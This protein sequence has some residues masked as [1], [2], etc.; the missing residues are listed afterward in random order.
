MFTFLWNLR[1]VAMDIKILIIDGVWME[2]PPKIIK[3]GLGQIVFNLWWHQL[4]VGKICKLFRSV[5]YSLY[6]MRLWTCAWHV[7][8]R[9]IIFSGSHSQF[10]TNWLQQLPEAHTKCIVYS[11]TFAILSNFILENIAKIHIF[12]DIKHLC[13]KYCLAYQYYAKEQLKVFVEVNTCTSP[14]QCWHICTWLL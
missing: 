7:Q 5:F 12:R 14:T 8:M 6:G 3:Q 13:E 9:A 1:W 4:R 2:C 10:N 11:A